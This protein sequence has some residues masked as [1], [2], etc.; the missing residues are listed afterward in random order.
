MLKSHCIHLFL[1]LWENYLELGNNK[2]YSVM[3]NEIQ[4]T[5][6][7]DNDKMLTSPLINTDTVSLQPASLHSVLQEYLQKQWQSLL[8]DLT[9]QPLWSENMWIAIDAVHIIWHTLS[10]WAVILILKFY[11]FWEVKLYHWMSSSC[12]FEGL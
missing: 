6:L 2:N 1:F 11:V 7:H 5:T 10:L 3:T 8:N 4:H 9:R 12:C